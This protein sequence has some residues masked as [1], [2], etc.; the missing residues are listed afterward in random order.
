ML[1]RRDALALVLAAAV[2]RPGRAASPEA[3]VS[4]EEAMVPS[5][6]GIQLYVRNKRPAGAGSFGPDRTLLFVHG[7]TYPAS[8]AFDLPLGGRSWMDVL[9]RRG[10]DVWLMDVRGYGRSTRPASLDQPPEANPP[11]GT[12]EDAVRDFAAVAE[13]VLRTRGLD[14]LNAMGWS[15]GTTIAA[16]FAAQAPG[17]V[18]RLVLYAPLWVLRE[19]PPIGAGGGKVGAY[20]A[21]T[22]EQALA[23]WL[24][25][26]PEEKRAGLI[27][28]GWFDRWADATWASDPGG[29]ARTPPVLR[30]TNGVLQDVLTRW[31]E[32]KPT[33]DPAA[34]TAPTLLVHGE[35]DRDT[36]AHMSQ[37]LFPLLTRAAWKQYTVIGEGTH[38]LM[39]ER[40]RGLLF[41][42]VQAF[43]ESPGPR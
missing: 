7:A 15:W 32:G 40:N 36:P 5:D 23:R 11:T 38:T 34:I 35:W 10:F 4:V 3:G 29:A 14:R 13:H 25:G 1:H 19:P 33:Y 2:A 12:T 22:R 18:N 26:V 9:A 30:A 39:M 41:E 20:R 42:T 17:K 43:L 6:P 24:N 31:G 27:P 16:G 28:P 8:T 37:A 21:V